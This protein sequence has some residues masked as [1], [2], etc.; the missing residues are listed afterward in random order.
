MASEKKDAGESDIECRLYS[1]NYSL[2]SLMTRYMFT[3]RGQPGPGIAGLRIDYNEIDIHD[4]FDQ[5]SEVYL[6]EVNQKG[7]VLHYES[8]DVGSLVILKSFIFRYQPSISKP[9]LPRSSPTASK[10]QPIS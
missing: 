4:N 1:Y 3:V 10:S 9:S 6:R 7:Q 5:L 2:C 8:L